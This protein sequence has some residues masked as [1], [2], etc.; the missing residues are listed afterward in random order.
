MQPFG[1]YGLSGTGPKAGGPLYL[2]SPGPATAGGRARRARRP[3]PRRSARYLDWL[4][5][6]GR[7]ALAEWLAEA[8][9]PACAETAL[10]G[11]VG[12]RN[13]YALR[14]R[15]RVAAIARTEA[16]LLLQLGAIL[17]GAIAP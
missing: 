5:S 12:E 15:G 7:G 13:L 14:P 4:R 8:G 16:G 1:G 3:T 11:P 2:G 10:P 9:L 17:A 6:T